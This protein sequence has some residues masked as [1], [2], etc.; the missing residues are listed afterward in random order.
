[1]T[2][3]F[4]LFAALLLHPAAWAHKPSDSYL[5]LRASA[6]SSDIAVRW[7][8]AL[9][10]LDY[11][12][13]LDRDGNG[14]ADLGRSAPAQRRHFPLCGE[15]SGAFIGREELSRWKPTAR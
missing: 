2:R 10:D 1:M 9:R 14:R 7:D 6:D 3:W 15:P 11:V 13:Q 12:L 5:T 4:A 8:I